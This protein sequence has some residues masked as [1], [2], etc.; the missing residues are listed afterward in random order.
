MEREVKM[1]NNVIDFLEKTGLNVIVLDGKNDEE[2]LGLRKKV[3]KPKPKATKKKPTEMDSDFKVAM[4]KLLKAIYEDYEDWGER[5]NIKFGLKKT[6]S[7]EKG[8]KYV[9]VIMEDKNNGYSKSVWGFVVLSKEDAKFKYGDIL[10]ASGWKAPARNKAR[11]N[12]FG[13]YSVKWTGPNY[14]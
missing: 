7:Y 10:L 5:A 11:G 2:V 9:K 4:D 6:Y 1:T 8:S 14:L 3:A 13:D 12:I